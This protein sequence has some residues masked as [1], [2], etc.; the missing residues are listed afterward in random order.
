VSVADGDGTY[1]PGSVMKTLLG[2]KSSPIL[3]GYDQAALAVLIKGGPALEVGGAGG[4]RGGGRGALPPGV[5]GGNLEPMRTPPQLTTLDGSP[6]P[7]PMGA[8]APRGGG[9]GGRGAGGFA[10]GGRGGGGRG[11]FGGGAGAPSSSAT[12]TA[13]VL[14]SYPNDASDLLLSGELVGGEN[15][16]GKAVL[17]DAP[18]GDGHIVMFANRP[19]WRNEPHGNYM[20]WFNAML[21]WNDLGGKK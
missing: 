5:G 18:V 9:A 1:V 7:V 13:K 21:N 14:L 11:G 6:A 2:D 17:V 20:L 4:G 15:L 3:Y 16:T 19:F 8:T 12:Q 10:G